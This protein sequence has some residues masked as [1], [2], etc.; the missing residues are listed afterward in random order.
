MRLTVKLIYG[1]PQE[2]KEMKEI[3]RRKRQKLP[4]DVTSHPGDQ[5]LP[6]LLFMPLNPSVM[7]IAA[8]G[9]SSHM[10]KVMSGSLVP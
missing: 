5:R 2:T 7:R 4:S 9:L 3:R 10:T 8:R 6:G 1:T